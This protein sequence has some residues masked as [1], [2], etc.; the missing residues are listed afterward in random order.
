LRG[1]SRIRQWRIPFREGRSVDI[2]GTDVLVITGLEDPVPEF[3][4]S[5]NR[6]HRFIKIMHR[7]RDV[8]PGED[9]YINRNGRAPRNVLSPVGAARTILKRISPLITRVIDLV[10]RD[11]GVAMCLF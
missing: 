1:I 11:P 8:F 7:D 9:G 6:D 2:E 3:L 4:L 5:L 10:R